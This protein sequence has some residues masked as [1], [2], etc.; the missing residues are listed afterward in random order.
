MHRQEIV[1]HLPDNEAPVQ[2][3]VL[4]AAIDAVPGPHP[5][6]TQAFQFQCFLLMVI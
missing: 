3:D 5:E 2:V 4:Y 1:G 6:V